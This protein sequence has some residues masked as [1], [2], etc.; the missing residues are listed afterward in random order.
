MIYRRLPH[1]GEEISALGLGTAYLYRASYQDIRATFEHAFDRGIN[2]VDLA[3]GGYKVFKPLGEAMEGRRKDIKIQLHL[4]ALYEEEGEYGWSRD[5]EAIKAMLKREFLDL[6]TDYADFLFLHCIDDEEDL[7]KV[8]KGGIYD[9][10][11]SLKREGKA[12]HLG[13]SSHTPKIAN[14]LL[15]LGIFDLFMF[16]VNAAYDLEEGDEFALGS[17]GER[18]ALYQKAREMGA[19]ISVMK[20]FLGGK[21]LDAS[22]SPFHVALTRG[23]CLKYALDTPGVV[24]ALPG[25]RGQE[26][27]D[28][29]IDEL[30]GDNDYSKILTGI[31]PKITGE[32]VYCDHCLPCPKGLDI[33]LINKYYDLAE[34]GDNLAVGHYEK[35]SHKA[36][37]CVSCGHCDR[38]CPFK[39]SQSTRMKEI[40]S[41]FGK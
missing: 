40:A 21:L 34:L 37:E 2:Y 13:F 25:V 36:S 41:Y 26:D 15:D 4:G 38:R 18:A 14:R 6:K 33:G 24:T 28:A 16:S 20:P 11:L 32:C 22:A 10:A 35:L 17:S 19:A 5:L 30:E 9:L 8:L 1:G 23:Q 12:R 27:I 39:V 7:D 31:R 3:A 29:L